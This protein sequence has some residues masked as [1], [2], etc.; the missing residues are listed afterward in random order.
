M[1]KLALIDG[2]ETRI[3]KKKIVPVGPAAGVLLLPKG[4]VEI[5]NSG[6]FAGLAYYLPPHYGYV[7]G[8]DSDG[9]KILVVLE[10]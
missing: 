6:N 10:P 8:L 2:D 5:R 9:Q 1:N 7:V 4:R 3:D